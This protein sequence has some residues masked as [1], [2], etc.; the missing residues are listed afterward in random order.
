MISAAVKQ[1]KENHK[2]VGNVARLP[3]LFMYY[4]IGTIHA[5]SLQLWNMV[6]SLNPFDTFT[7]SNPSIREKKR[8]VSWKYLA[9][10]VEAKSILK[11]VS[12]ESRH[13]K[14]NGLLV[15]LLSFALEKQYIELIQ[16]ECMPSEIQ[17][18][19]NVVRPVHLAGG[20]A[21]RGKCIGNSIGAF[22]TR[23]LSTQS[24]LATSYHVFAAF[25]TTF[26][27]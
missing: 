16:Q 4:V 8:S 13:A 7:T 3:G 21:L 25:P 10:V 18:T 2:N 15:S 12:K 19:I 14:L 26:T 24:I 22:V 6:T 27:E 23:C 5:L 11:A 17:S 9:P 1:H 20:L